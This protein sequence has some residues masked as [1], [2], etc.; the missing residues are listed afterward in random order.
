VPCGFSTDPPGLPIGLQIS[1]KPF[2]DA[3]VLAVGQAY[4]RAT[5]WHTKRPRL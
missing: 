2:Q 3:L 1:A 5:G 4:E